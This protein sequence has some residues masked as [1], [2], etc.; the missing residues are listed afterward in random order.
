L[1]FH[2][3]NI[4]CPR[5]H[6]AHHDHKPHGFLSALVILSTNHKDIGTL[7][8]IFAILAGIIG[9]A[10]SVVMRMELQEPGIQIFHGLAQMVYGLRAMP[11]STPASR[12]STSSPRRMR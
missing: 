11:P 2:G 5:D 6:N 4:S 12:C 7:Y 3:W 10:L 8:L 9:G 1:R